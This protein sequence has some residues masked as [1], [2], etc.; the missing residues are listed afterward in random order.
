MA[1]GGGGLQKLMVG[2]L[3]GRHPLRR[4]PFQAA[5]QEVD[6]IAVLAVQNLCQ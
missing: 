6:E 2:R 3:I 4:I 5:L 1:A